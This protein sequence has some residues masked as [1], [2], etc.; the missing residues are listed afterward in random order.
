MFE[1]KNQIL[2]FGIAWTGLCVNWT[3]HFASKCIGTI[4]NLTNL[5]S[6][7]ILNPAHTYEVWGIVPSSYNTRQ[8]SVM[9]REAKKKRSKYYNIIKHWT[10]GRVWINENWKL[11]H[12][13]SYHSRK[14]IHPWTIYIIAILVLPW[15]H[16]R[17]WSL[18]CSIKEK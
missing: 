7:S 18:E 1:N 6:Y 11:S 8:G 4:S 2:I 14:H 13:I 17:A 10:W 9:I 12:Y 16:F 3:E 15:I 5:D